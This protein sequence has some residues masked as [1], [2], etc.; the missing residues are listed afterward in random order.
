[1]EDLSAGMRV[2]FKFDGPPQMATSKLN[3]LPATIIAKTG[4]LQGEDYYTIE[5]DDAFVVTAKR[6]ELVLV[7]QAVSP[8]AQTSPMSKTDVMALVKTASDQLALTMLKHPRPEQVFAALSSANLPA[9]ALEAARSGYSAAR[10]APTD[11]S[12]LLTRDGVDRAVGWLQ[13][14]Q[15]KLWASLEG[16]LAD[17]QRRDESLETAAIIVV[18]VMFMLAVRA[19]EAAAAGE[20]FGIPAS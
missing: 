18:T 9:A 17:P 11:I 15:P 6:S 5:F 3:G 16:Q 19:F 12:A 8:V 7:V 10:R 4:V 14:Q 13:G 2:M 20:R 1:M